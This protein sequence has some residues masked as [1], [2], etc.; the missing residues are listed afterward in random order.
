[1]SPFARSLIGLGPGLALCFVIVLAARLLQALEIR[2][3]GHPYLEALV[4]AILLGA[5][6]RTSWEPGELWRPGIRCSAATLLEVAVVLL[7]LSLDLRALIAGGPALPLGI[8]GVVALSL[9]GSYGVSRAARMPHRMAVLIA[10]GNSICGN[11]AIAAVASVIGATGR[12]VASAIAF[13]AILGVAV[14]L[15]LPLLVP[16]L[17]LSTTQYG[18][19][20]GL[21]VYAVPQVLAATAP[22]GSLSMQTG[23]LV[24]L[25]RVLMLGPVVLLLSVARRRRN[26]GDDP[27]PTGAPWRPGRFMPWFIIGFLLAAALNSIGLVPQPALGPLHHFAGLLTAVAMAAM[28]LG[29]E[30]RALA[31]VGLRVTAAVTVSLLLLIGL[32][33]TAIRFVGPA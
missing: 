33:L 1:M 13:T 24:K 28:G 9:V 26:A 16:M 31:R 27:S 21:T 23:T 17:D 18:A 29:V 10:C 14:V 7:G 32:S 30:V 25:L 15:A 4:I 6:L 2:V 12:E 8:A 5:A 11:S 3:F 22:F 19:L 20:A